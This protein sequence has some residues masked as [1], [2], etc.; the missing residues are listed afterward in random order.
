MPSL[1]TADL[2]DWRRTGCERYK[3]WSTPQSDTIDRLSEGR[4]LQ[5]IKM[6]STKCRA[7]FAM[8]PIIMHCSH[9]LLFHADVV[10]SSDPRAEL[11][12]HVYSWDRTDS[13]NQLPW[14]CLCWPH[15][16]PT[17][18]AL[19]SLGRLGRKLF[20]F[21]KLPSHN[22]EFILNFHVEHHLHA[23]TFVVSLA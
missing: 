20:N 9:C 23:T 10:G 6:W 11:E 16:G 18:M 5:Y 14:S 17:C 22:P 3:V 13:F 4:S 12:K 21:M 15:V 1:P 2:W 19:S 7:L 8:W